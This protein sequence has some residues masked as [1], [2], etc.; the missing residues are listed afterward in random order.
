MAG[1]LHPDR[2]RREFRPGLGRFGKHSHA[3]SL[4]ENRVNW[5]DYAK[6]ICIV[7]VVMMHTTLGV[8]KAAGLDSWLHPFITGPNPSACRI[9][10]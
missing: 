5:V 4:D 7:L 10:S 8:E 2:S 6:G 3:A 9:S 1:I